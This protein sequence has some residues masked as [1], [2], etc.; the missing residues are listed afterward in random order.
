MYSG[1]FLLA[2]CAFA[3]IFD[4]AKQSQQLVLML[5]IGILIGTAGVMAWK[6]RNATDGAD[7]SER[8]TESGATTSLESLVEKKTETISRAPSMPLAPQIPVNSRLGISVGDQPAG[9][10][11]AVKGL[12]SKDPHW[13]AV[14]DEREGQPGWIM[15]AARVRPGETEVTVELLRASKAG[16]RYYA[17][18]LGDDG[19]DDFDKSKDLPPMDPDQIVIVSFKAN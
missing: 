2:E 1:P 12:A 14:Y 7:T 5:I 13:V 18:I 6:T 10:L 15:G 19:S 11:V 17:A 3:T 9:K 16:E 4:M 8:T